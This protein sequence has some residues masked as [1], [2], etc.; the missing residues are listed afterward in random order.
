MFGTTQVCK[1][2]FMWIIPQLHYYVEHHYFVSIDGI[3]YEQICGSPE[4]WC[5]S[6][7]SRG[8]PWQRVW[9]CPWFSAAMGGQMGPLRAAC[10]SGAAQTGEHPIHTSPRHS[11]QHG[12]PGHTPL[13]ASLSTI[14]HGFWTFWWAWKLK[15]IQH[16][17]KSWISLLFHGKDIHLNLS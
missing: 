17:Q 1:S 6:G 14:L 13:S 16:I 15:H 8:G 12:E 4:T 9:L 3:V 7:G 11:D 10:S 5:V 2:F